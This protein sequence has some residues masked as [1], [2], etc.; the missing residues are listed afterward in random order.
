MNWDHTWVG[1]KRAAHLQAANAH[2]SAVF[3][4]QAGFHASSQFQPMQKKKGS[5]DS[6]VRAD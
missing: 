1:Q 2:V 4:N 3:L 5:S 6:R